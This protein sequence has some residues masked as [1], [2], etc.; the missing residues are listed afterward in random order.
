MSGIR[1]GLEGIVLLINY[2][3][4]AEAVSLLLGHKRATFIIIE[5]RVFSPFNRELGSMGKFSY[6]IKFKVDQRG[7]IPNGTS[8]F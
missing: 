7:N 1:L 2:L 6:V 5:A 4:L 3:R 8:F